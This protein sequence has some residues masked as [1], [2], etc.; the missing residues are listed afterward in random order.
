M[1]RNLNPGEGD[2]GEAQAEAETQLIQ[3]QP[4]LEASA[5]P[6]PGAKQI[7]DFRLGRLLGRGGM[8]AVY[9]AYEQSMRRTVALKILDSGIDPSA[10]ELSRFEREAW[11]AR[12]LSRRSA[13]ALTPELTIWRW[14]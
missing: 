10:N 13:K 1:E 9:E 8:G 3:A 11:I 2:G 12:A 4:A 6:K 7:G 14:S 5:L